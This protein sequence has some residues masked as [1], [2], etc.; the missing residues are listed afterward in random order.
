MPDDEDFDA[1]YAAWGPRL[2][3]NIYLGTGDYGRA[4]DC[5]QEA[6]VRAWLRWG[7]LGGSA[8]PV[9]WVRTVAWR[10]ACNDWRRVVRQAAALLRR[11]ADSDVVPPSDEAI[12]VRDVLNRL[13]PHQGLVIAL[14]Y[15]EDL[16][17]KQVAH[18]L[19]VPEGTVKTRLA[20][21][22]ASMKT[23]LTMEEEAS[24]WAKQS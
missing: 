9:A 16:S 19:G 13:P 11:G 24:S 17:I 15:F 20:R 7:Q 1:F 6:F 22:R 4:R 14:Y 8:D 12:A 3:R 23:A 10:L 5:V 21:G 18:L 2:V